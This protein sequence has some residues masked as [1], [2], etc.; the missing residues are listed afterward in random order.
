[1]MQG[2]TSLKKKNTRTKQA[3]HTHSEYLMLI[4]FQR[5]QWLRERAS[6]LSYRYMYTACLVKFHYTVTCN[7]YVFAVGNQSGLQHRIH[8]G[9]ME[10]LSSQEYDV[11]QVGKLPPFSRHLAAILKRWPQATELHYMTSLTTANLPSHRPP[12]SPDFTQDATVPCLVWS[13]DPSETL[14]TVQEVFHNSVLLESHVAASHC[15]THART[16][17]K[18][19]GCELTHCIISVNKTP[20]RKRKLAVIWRRSVLVPADYKI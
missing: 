9:L 8:F 5:Q 19:L 16:H 14:S 4:A 17:M 15:H 3:T 11:A 2:T 13:P 7:S 18:P 12:R 10:L 20:K 1:M 6:M